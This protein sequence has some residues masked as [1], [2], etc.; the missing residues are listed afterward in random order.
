MITTFEVG[1]RFRILNEASPALAEILKQIRSINIA[2]AKAKEGFASL[3]TSVSGLRLGT[4]VGEV[5]AL[6]ASWG[7]VTK[8]AAAARLAM[9]T[10]ARS[11]TA[12]IAAATG[13]RHR[14]GWLGG[15]AHITG[16]SVPLGAGSHLRVGGGA[17][18]AAVGAL[19]WGVDQAAK[20]ADYAWRMEDIAGLP[21]DETNH[22]KFRKILQDAQI[23]TG[24]SL[25]EVGKSALGVIR[26][27][28]ATPGNG[29]DTLPEMLSSAATEARRKGT[30]LEESM[31]S[32]AELAHQFKA[33]TPQ[34]MQ[35]LFATF[36]ALSTADPRSLSAMTRASGYAVPTLSEL[37]VDPSSVL[38][39]GT[40]LAQ[41][42]ISST[43]SGTWIR[44]A[45]TRALP[46]IVLGHSASN[47][48]HEEALRA[49]GLVKDGKP[50]WFT[51]GRP[52]ELK[53]FEI[54]GD[55]L[56]KMSPTER[57]VYGRAA[58]G[59][60]GSG[61]VAVLGDPVVNQRLHAIDAM[62]KSQSYL[63]RYKS[64]GTD[65]QAGSTM[66]DARTALQTFNVTVGEL[67]RLTLPILN[68]VLDDFRAT[69][70]GVRKALPGGDGKALATVGARGAEGIIG[71]ALTG[72]AIGRIGGPV[73]MFGGAVIGGVGGVA[74]GYLEQ[75]H[76]AN[77]AKWAQEDRDRDKAIAAVTR[78]FPA[79]PGGV[80]PGG[81]S[82]TPLA[83]T[84][85]LDGSVLGRV[86]MNLGANSFEGQAPAFNGASQYQGSSAAHSDK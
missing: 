36:A 45:V 84:L 66:Q 55:A 68:K 14:P 13:G 10:A 70:E 32:A 67:G 82:T 1:A 69:L 22:A 15:G 16:P 44:E 43:K 31:T 33:Y 8:N 74:A 63:D 83:V 6:A 11:T 80:F 12:P 34:A 2:L 23:S 56:Q 57:A 37:G 53:M 20:T 77:K 65:Y 24:F 38:L 58:F 52:D 60:Q 26:L 5:D 71:G 40:G 28:Q 78:G 30:G 42:G 54:A 62:T 51:N 9:N 17:G 61:A 75:Q 41:A 19:G 49:L 86:L 4:A 46:G 72:A 76:E 27:M 7:S 3:G 35:D 39:A 47:K 50:T 29:V 21:H 81:T 48:K 85:N 59:A 73:G 64:F 79:A 18:M 25:D